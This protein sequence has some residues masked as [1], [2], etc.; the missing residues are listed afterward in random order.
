MCTS[1]LLV[2]DALPVQPE[3]TIDDDTVELSGISTWVPLV[4]VPHEAEPTVH[5]NEALP[6]PPAAAVAV[7]VTLYVPATE[8][9]PE[10]RPD[11][12][13]DRPVGRPVADHVYGAVPPEADSCSDTEPPS[14]V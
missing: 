10:T 9:V 6:E 4:W 2:A 3:T 11:E 12:L 13:I 8:A 1:T 5:V 14:A 7:A